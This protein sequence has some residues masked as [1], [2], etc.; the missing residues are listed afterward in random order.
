[1]RQAPSVK[2][3][4]RKTAGN[5]LE[6]LCRVI[7]RRSRSLY[8]TNFNGF[9]FVSDALYI[10][11]PR[12]GLEAIRISAGSPWKKVCNKCYNV[13]LRWAVWP[14]NGPRS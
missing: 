9:Q 13:A 7:L 11:L 3:A 12:I 8:I 5:R 14:E 1:M 6:N 10:R 2:R 4:P